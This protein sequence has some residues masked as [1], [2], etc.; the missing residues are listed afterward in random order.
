MIKLTIDPADW[1]PFIMDAYEE[2]PLVP[3]GYRVL[4][5]SIDKTLCLNLK[6]TPKEEQEDATS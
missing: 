5:V 4:A 3:E 2:T 1:G 6:L